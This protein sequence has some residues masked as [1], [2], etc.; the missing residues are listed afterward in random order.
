MMRIS[1]MARDQGLVVGCPALE[2]SIELKGPGLLGGF[3]VGM[4]VHGLL[5]V[6][7]IR[8]EIRAKTEAAITRGAPGG[9]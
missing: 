2:N 3:P 8:G 5:S 6:V 4:A 7:E 9:D 1:R